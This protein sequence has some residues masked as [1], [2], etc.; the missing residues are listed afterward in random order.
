MAV[1]AVVAG[2][3]L[4]LVAPPVDAAPTVGTTPPA[5]APAPASTAVV[6]GRDWTLSSPEAKAM[7][8]ALVDQAL[9]YAFVDGRNT[10]G[11]VIVKG[12]QIVG[13]RYAKGA[14]ATSWAAS[15]SVA[16]SF[17]GTLIGIAVDEGKIPNVEVPM[18]T[19]F[20]EWIGT[21]RA[22]I[23]LRHVLQMEAGLDWDE[24]YYGAGGGSEIIAMV[25]NQRDQLAFAA[26]RPV[27]HPPGTVFNYSSG[28]AMLLSG[29]L[30][31]ATGMSAEAY[32]RTRLIEPL[33]FSKFDWWRDADGNTLT[34]CCLDTTTRDFAR[35]GL[36]YLN[37]GRW[38]GKQ[39]ISQAWVDAATTGTAAS[40]NSYGYQWWVQPANGTMP[41]YYSARGHD[42]QYIH[43]FPSLDL[44]VARNGYYGKSPCPAVA[45]PALLGF[46]PP[47]G[48][49]PGWGTVDPESW[50]EDELLA[51]IV[52]SVTGSAYPAKTWPEPT[53]AKPEPSTPAPAP[54][55]GAEG[56]AP[57]PAPAPA[58]ESPE[59]PAPVVRA[60]TPVVANPR[61]TG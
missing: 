20:P 17:A 21:P 32:A 54:C 35:L 16:K 9:D 33:G 45:D 59:A 28:T 18:T 23:T 40:G 61:F 6:P 31:K 37:G 34:Y 14:D 43:V 22:G 2:L 4:A 12:G 49:V 46:Y 39:I 53:G 11:V 42:G 52:A 48:L 56:P 5:V 15:W 58:P 51:P 26:D 38:G 47:Q 19:Y 24:D 36:L 41:A 8:P 1:A 7:D 57:A 30:E 29:V 27:E 50:S 25:G 13:E 44:I 3:G 10:Q 55:P 60:A